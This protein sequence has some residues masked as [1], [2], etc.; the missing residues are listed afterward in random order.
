MKRELNALAAEFKS[1]LRNADEDLLACV[2]AAPS[3]DGG[4]NPPAASAPQRSQ[5]APAMK[6]NQQEAA[7]PAPAKAER[8]APRAARGSRAGQLQALCA[9]VQ[10]CRKCQLGLSRI[11]PVFGVG[12]PDSPVMFVGE[13]PGYQEDR[14]GEPFV[15]RA[16]QLLDKILLAMSL[17]R[18]QVYIANIVKCHPMID[19]S[20][21]DLHSNDRPPL[22]QEY[23]ACRPYLDQ[24]VDIIKPRFIVALGATA[25]RVLLNSSSSL[26]ALRGRFHEMPSSMFAD[27]SGVRLLATY[28]PAALLRNPNW[29]K[30]AWADMKLLMAELGL[31]PSAENKQ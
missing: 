30:D 18:E 15:G 9:Q 10:D 1:Y 24:Q 25:A 14:Q 20:R 11:K 5:Q 2:Q 16:G 27:Y 13:G 12:N 22:P 31:K 3:P 23:N 28:H 29:K 6:K 19:P 4:P 26:S 7:Q 8:P 17:S 21:P